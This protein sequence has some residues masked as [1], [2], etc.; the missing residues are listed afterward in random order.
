MS[1][2]LEKWE[3]QPGE[4]LDY[5]ISFEDFLDL[6]GDT[7]ASHVVNAPAGITLEA[8]TLSAG[9]VKVWLSGGTDGQTYIIEAV[10]TTTG[11]RVKEGEIAIKVKE[12]R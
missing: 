6:R 5:D 8:S 3:K 7:G 11:G 9:V 4:T 2:V 1:G 12:T 10:V